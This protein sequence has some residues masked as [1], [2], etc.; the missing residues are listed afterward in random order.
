MVQTTTSVLVVDILGPVVHKCGPLIATPRISRYA[1]LKK[2]TLTTL[3]EV[4]VWCLH[5]NKP[6]EFFLHDTNRGLRAR[7]D[8]ASGALL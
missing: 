5:F 3:A 1:I 2:V 4:V 7:L 6:E 8:V